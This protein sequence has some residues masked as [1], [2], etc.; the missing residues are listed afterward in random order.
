MYAI[1]QNQVS[2]QEHHYVNM[3]GNNKMLPWGLLCKLVMDEIKTLSACGHLGN[4]IL[5]GVRQLQQPSPYDDTLVNVAST[6]L[7][8]AHSQQ[9]GNTLLDLFT[10]LIRSGKID[11]TLEG[12][13]MEVLLSGELDAVISNT[14]GLLENKHAFEMYETWYYIISNWPPL[15]RTVCFAKQSQLINTARH[16][17]IGISSYLK[18]RY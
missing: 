14:L 13:V 17:G 15:E 18:Y 9:L 4:T 10:E 2:L 16:C 1:I 8:W 6:R 3:Y 11:E 5:T 7:H 12:A